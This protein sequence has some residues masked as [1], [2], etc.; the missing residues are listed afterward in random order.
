MFLF[1][2]VIYYTVYVRDYHHDTSFA[3]HFF[4]SL[5]NSFLFIRLGSNREVEETVIAIISQLIIQLHDCNEEDISQ[6]LLKKMTDNNGE[7]L[8]RCAEL[9]VKY[10]K[11]LLSSE[12][13]IESTAEALKVHLIF[14]LYYSITLL[15]NIYLLL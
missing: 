10:A 13:Q 7:K 2:G 3:T 11:L 5:H 15:P 12:K 8:D 14:L 4:V 1:L 9:C 6:R